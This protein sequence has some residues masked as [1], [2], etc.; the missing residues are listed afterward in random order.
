LTMNE[1]GGFQVVEFTAMAV[2]D[3]SYGI[4]N[5]IPRETTGSYTFPPASI[6]TL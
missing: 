5:I 6:G 2:A 3:A 4:I 1:Y